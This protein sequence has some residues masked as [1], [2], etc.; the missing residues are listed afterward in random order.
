MTNISS[1]RGRATDLADTVNAQ[2]GVNV[3][4]TNSSTQILAADDTRV[5]IRLDNT[6]NQDVHIAFDNTA[7]TNDI[8]IP[9]GDT[10]GYLTIARFPFITDVIN[11]ITNAG[12]SNIK[13]FEVTTT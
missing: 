2:G 13:I 9:K 8:I 7:T 4:V 12:S 10:L 6:G 3:N 5:A 11:G 1:G